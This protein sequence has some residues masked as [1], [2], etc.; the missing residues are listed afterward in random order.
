LG[1]LEK[2]RRITIKLKTKNVRIW[3][4]FF[5]LCTWPFAGSYKYGNETAGTTKGDFL[6]QMRDHQLDTKLPY[7]NL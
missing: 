1:N 7:N 4:G 2:G 6:D 5:C 3:T